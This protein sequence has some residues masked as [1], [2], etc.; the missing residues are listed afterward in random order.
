M[1]ETVWLMTMINLYLYSCCGHVTG[2]VCVVE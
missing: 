1:D 2:V